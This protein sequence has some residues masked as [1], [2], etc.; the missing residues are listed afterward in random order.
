MLSVTVTC[1]WCKTANES[2]EPFSDLPLTIQNSVAKATHDFFKTETMSKSEKYE[3]WI[4]DEK[5]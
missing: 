2:Y 5:F 1:N 4:C 3:C